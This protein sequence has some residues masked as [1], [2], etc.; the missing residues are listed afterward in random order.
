MPDIVL[1]AAHATASTAEVS[2]PRPAGLGE[3]SEFGPKLSDP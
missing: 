1:D 3:L 2:V